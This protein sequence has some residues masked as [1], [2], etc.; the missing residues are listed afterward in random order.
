M[1]RCTDLNDIINERKLQNMWSVREGN[2][3][4]IIHNG[5]VIYK[6]WIGNKGKKTQPSILINK[7]F[8]NEYIN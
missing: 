3:L 1:G 6:R 4:Y 7:S 8:P 5:E 2:H